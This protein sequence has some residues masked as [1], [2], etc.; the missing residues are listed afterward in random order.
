MAA[1]HVFH[2]VD[3]RAVDLLFRG[4]LCTADYRRL[5]DRL[6][7]ASSLLVWSAF[8]LWR[9]VSAGAFEWILSLGLAS[10]F[11]RCRAGAL[12]VTV[13]IMRPW[14]NALQQTRPLRSGCSLRVL[15]AGSLS[16]G[17]AP[18][19]RSG[20]A[21]VLLMLTTATGC[22]ERKSSKDYDPNIIS[23]GWRV[24][25]RAAEA[26]RYSEAARYA[27]K[28]L[29]SDCPDRQY[30]MWK[31]WETVFSERPDY[32][33]MSQRFGNSLFFLYDESPSATRSVIADM[34][35]RPHFDV[36]R[37]GADLRADVWK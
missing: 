23:G 30:A 26:E 12:F 24:V 28:E 6:R 17:L 27:V 4:E 36:S 2:A 9:Q 35:G 16:L 34:F 33:D 14:P 15:R 13:E 29:T 18:F 19:M 5:P 31:W 32:M 1:S 25:R 3:R 20:T 8:H 10:V 37:P 21:I 11:V 7:E 22:V